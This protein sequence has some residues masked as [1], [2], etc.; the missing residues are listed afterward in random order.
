MKIWDDIPPPPAA[1]NGS[2]TAVAARKN[3]ISPRYF[4][5]FPAKGPIWGEFLP[6]WAAGKKLR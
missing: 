6:P 2:A 4:W 5:K 3:R 1:G